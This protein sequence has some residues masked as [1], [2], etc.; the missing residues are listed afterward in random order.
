M[1]CAEN[2]AYCYSSN[3]RK[4]RRGE[5]GARYSLQL[6]EAGGPRGTSLR[7]YFETY[8]LYR[9]NTELLNT[10]KNDAV[11]SISYSNGVR[12]GHQ[13]NAQCLEPP[14]IPSFFTLSSNLLPE[15]L[16]GTVVFRGVTSAVLLRPSPNYLSKSDAFGGSPWP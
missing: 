16:L 11:D 9:S 7:E 10:R 2:L 1:S 15:G 3:N 4:G 14:E 5:V 13:G 8:C 6:V 12:F